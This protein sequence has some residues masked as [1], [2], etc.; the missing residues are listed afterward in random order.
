MALAATANGVGAGAGNGVAATAPLRRWRRRWW[1]R[2]SVPLLA[3]P[4]GV[5]MHALTVVLRRS[6]LH[7][8]TICVRE[9]ARARVCTR[10]RAF[11]TVRVLASLKLHARMLACAHA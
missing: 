3:E 4:V 2:R 11:V 7:T 5:Y 8:C 1:R 10:A 9:F 6:H